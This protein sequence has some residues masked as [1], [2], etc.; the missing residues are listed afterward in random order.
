MKA[1]PA[2]SGQFLCSMSTFIE[3]QLDRALKE[4][5]AV[6]A[7]PCDHVTQA[8]IRDNYFFDDGLPDKVSRD[9]RAEN[10]RRQKRA[11]GY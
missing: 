9:L 7:P 5:N 10:A 6:D 8:W 11:L 1:A 3:D 4:R 2:I